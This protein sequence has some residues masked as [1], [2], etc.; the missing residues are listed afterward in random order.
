MRKNNDTP[1][2]KHNN[3]CSC[4]ECKD[5][6]KDYYD[7]SVYYCDDVLKKAIVTSESINPSKLKDRQCTQ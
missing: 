1:A 4:D 3:E 2:I 7:G 5:F 6:W